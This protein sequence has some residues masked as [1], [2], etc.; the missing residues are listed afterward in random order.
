MPNRSKLTGSFLFNRPAPNSI[1][2]MSLFR[3][4]TKNFQLLNLQGTK[5]LWLLVMKSFFE[6][7]ILIHTLEY[8][9]HL[10]EKH[11]LG[12]AMGFLVDRLLGGN[13]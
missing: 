2:I 6:R 13:N 11:K 1:R 5:V 7:Q 10:P 3:M 8:Q 4:K 9:T 12:R